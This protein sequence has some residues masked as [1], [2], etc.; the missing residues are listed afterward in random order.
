MSGNE[1]KARLL[2]IKSKTNPIIETISV[3]ENTSPEERMGLPHVN[4]ESGKTVAFLDSNGSMFYVVSGTIVV[5]S[6]E[7]DISASV[8]MGYISSKDTWTRTYSG[9]SISHNTSFMISNT[10]Y[11]RFY[12][13]NTSS[14]NIQVSGGAI[15][16]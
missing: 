11:Y 12:I 13:T 14:K 8:D 5:F 16:F 7:L 3:R 15:S 10:G 1:R 9:T 4:I 2:N 6:I